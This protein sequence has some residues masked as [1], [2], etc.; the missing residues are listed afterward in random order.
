MNTLNK[1]VPVVLYFNCIYE[2]MTRFNTFKLK[3]MLRVDFQYKF[4][5]YIQIR[6]PIVKMIITRL[7]EQ[8]HWISHYCGLIPDSTK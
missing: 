1:K 5:P 7:I 3:K 4:K 2:E 8:A 6:A